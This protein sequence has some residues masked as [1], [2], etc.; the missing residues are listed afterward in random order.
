M[1]L[2][3]KRQLTWC[4]VIN[5][6]P[7]NLDELSL[8]KKKQILYAFSKAVLKIVYSFHIVNWAANLEI[9]PLSLCRFNLSSH[10]RTLER[11]IVTEFD[12]ETFNPS[13]IDFLHQ[14]KTNKNK[15]LLRKSGIHCYFASIY[16]VSSVFV[17]LRAFIVV[18]FWTNVRNEKIISSTK[19]TEKYFNIF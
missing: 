12:S 19:V 6:K 2:W 17:R 18:K 13:R 3:E 14:K 1:S 10:C 16:R 8:R 7:Q 5:L 11:G 4:H 9:E 15:L